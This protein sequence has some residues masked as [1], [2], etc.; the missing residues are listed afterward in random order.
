MQ[1]SI[2]CQPPARCEGNVTDTLRDCR[3]KLTNLIKIIKWGKIKA[4]LSGRPPTR[5]HVDSPSR[6]FSAASY[7][8]LESISTPMFFFDFF[9]F[10][11]ACL[12]MSLPISLPSAIA[13][14]LESWWAEQSY[15]SS[16]SV[17]PLQSSC[18]EGEVSGVNGR[19]LM[20]NEWPYYANEVQQPLS[21]VPQNSWWLMLMAT[22]SFGWCRNP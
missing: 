18:T 3:Q 11:S 22:F 10:Q 15:L 7:F 5:V 17:P 12:V 4:E 20:H 1:A 21:Y 2:S 9:M 14:P 8:S 6:G 13:P 16:P 19:R